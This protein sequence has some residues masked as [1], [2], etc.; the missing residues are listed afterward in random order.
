MSKENTTVKATENAKSEIVTYEVSAMNGNKDTLTF[1]NSDLIKHTQ[2]IQR[3]RD[4]GNIAILAI[5]HELAKMDDDESYKSAGFKSLADYGRVV[6]DYKPSTISLY[7]KSAHAFLTDD[8][9]GNVAIKDGLPKLSMGQMIELAPLVENG[10]ITPVI[11]LF[12]DGTVNEM[13]ST[14]KMRDAVQ[15]TKAIDGEVK[16]VSSD[17]A[18]KSDLA[19]ADK[20]GDYEDAKAKKNFDAQAYATTTLDASF[21]AFGNF[22]LSLDGIEHNAT[23]DTKA[24]KIMKLMSELRAELNK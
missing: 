5:A 20:L 8:E 10:D 6:F 7:L 4:A 17:K 9:N 1:Y 13:M 22:K 18:E 2:V 11:Q 3:M 23:M 15:S 14:K 16:E 12:A 24:D 19:K 21:E